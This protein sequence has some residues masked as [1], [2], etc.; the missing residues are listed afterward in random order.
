MTRILAPQFPRPR[1]SI[2]FFLND[3]DQAIKIGLESIRVQL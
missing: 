2:R 1:N 3:L